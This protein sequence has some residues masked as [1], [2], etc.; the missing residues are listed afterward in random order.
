MATFQS[1][2]ITETGLLE[3]LTDCNTGGDEF[4]N[5]GIEFV[6]FVNDHASEDYNITFTPPSTTITTSLHGAVTKSAITITVNNG[7]EVY[8]GPFKPNVWNTASNKVAVTYLTTGGAALSTVNSGAHALKAEVLY[9]DP[10]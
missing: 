1:R 5:S 9:I 6:K 2:K 7:E 3:T 8:A 4:F 10:K